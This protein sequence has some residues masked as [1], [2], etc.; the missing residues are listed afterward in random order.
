[1]AHRRFLIIRHAVRK[2]GKHFKGQAGHR[3]KP[4]HRRGKDAFNMIKD[5]E[6]IFSQAARKNQIW[7]QRLYCSTM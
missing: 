6:V 7:M 4:M 1:M 3:R 2:K 5:L